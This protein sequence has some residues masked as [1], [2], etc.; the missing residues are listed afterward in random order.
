M[1][2]GEVH[3]ERR[4]PGDVPGQESLFPRHNL[5]VI[6][7]DDAPAELG[8]AYALRTLDD[9]GGADPWRLLVWLAWGCCLGTVGWTIGAV[10]GALV[11]AGVIA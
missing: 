5:R 11:G 3:A 1:E 4:Q 9:Q 6:S 10:A 7:P 8:R 2:A